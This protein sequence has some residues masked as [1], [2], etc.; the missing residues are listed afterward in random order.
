MFQSVK[1]FGIGQPSSYFFLDLQV[2]DKQALAWDACSRSKR[3]FVSAAES[4]KR[5]LV[6]TSGLRTKGLAS[7]VDVV[8]SLRFHNARARSGVK[9]ACS[10]PSTQP[11]AQGR[12]AGG[13]GGD[14][15]PRGLGRAAAGARPWVPRARRARRAGAGPLS[16]RKKEASYEDSAFARAS[17]RSSM[18]A[19]ARDDRGGRSC[20]GSGG[21][22]GAG[23]CGS[24]SRRSRAGAGTCSAG[25]TL[26]PS[27]SRTGPCARRWRTRG[28]RPTRRTARR[29]QSGGARGCCYSRRS[30]S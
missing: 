15:R 18:A 9:R 27:C 6:Y 29:T 22:R 1:R 4:S 13:A 21:G 19:S 20:P 11:S 25:S 26:R 24:R 5:L 30:Q 7:H 2:T 8:F 3:E 10:A 12:L 14:E 28:R 23:R 17:A 16:L